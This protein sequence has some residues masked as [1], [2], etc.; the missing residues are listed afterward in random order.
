M[1]SFAAVVGF[2]GGLTGVGVAD[3]TVRCLRGFYCLLRH[4]FPYGQVDGSEWCIG[5][6]LSPELS[7]QPWPYEYSPVDVRRETPTVFVYAHQR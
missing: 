7:S 6:W 1:L 3:C 2:F 4:P 5:Q